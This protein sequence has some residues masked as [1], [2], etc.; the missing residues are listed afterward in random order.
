M[1]FKRPVKG[2]TQGVPQ[3]VPQDVPQ[4]DTQDY[5]LDKWIENQIRLNPQRNH[6]TVL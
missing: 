3:D 2:D 5:N 4:G 6:G 1:I